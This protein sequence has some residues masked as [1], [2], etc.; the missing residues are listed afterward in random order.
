[1]WIAMLAFAAGLVA[2]SVLSAGCSG[3]SADRV[4][5]KP[6]NGSLAVRTG[7]DV[8]LRYRYEN[9][10]FKP[11]VRELFT[12]SGVNVLRDA[13]ADHLHH[14]ALMFA[15]AADGVNF[16]EE[17]QRPGRQ[18]HRSFAKIANVGGGRAA[19]MAGFDEH[20]DWVNPRT[21]QVLLKEI[22]TIKAFG[23]ADGDV[24]LMTWHTRLSPPT[25]KDSVTLSGSAYFG[26]GI[27]FLKSMDSGGSFVNSEGG[28]GVKGTNDKRAGWCAYSAMADGKPVTIAVFDHPDNE[29]HPATW[30]TM[31]NPFAYIAAT[32]GLHKEPLKVESGR[33]LVLSYGVALWDGRIEAGRIGRVYDRWLATAGGL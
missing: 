32:L 8:V 12:P 2:L 22:R 10:P 13:P 19:S 1:M 5:V 20:L 3:N 7:G 17:Q 30:F 21:G 18:E 23:K 29:R 16:W 24:T 26:L 6:E 31:D 25:G 11:Y 33:P 4:T 27:R 15:V 28:S 9:V 14:H